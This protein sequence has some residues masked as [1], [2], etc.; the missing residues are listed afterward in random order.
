[1]KKD[2]KT[3]HGN[4]AG[5]YFIMESFTF[6]QIATLKYFKK[7]IR[8]TF[9]NQSKM[10]QKHNIGATNLFFPFV[11]CLRGNANQFC[12]IPL[13][14]FVL[15]AVFFDFLRYG[16]LINRNCRSY[17]L[18]IKSTHLSRYRIACISSGR[19]YSITPDDPRN[20]A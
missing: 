11:N 14:N 5:G 19:T 6:S 9:Q 18:L 7:I 13:R 1:M 15:L 20:P 17:H 8:F 2:S 16:N 4:A 3:A 10:R 12:K